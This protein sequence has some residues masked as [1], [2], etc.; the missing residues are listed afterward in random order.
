MS[1][2]LP[3]R[4]KS[5]WHAIA[6]LSRIIKLVH[7]IEPQEKDGLGYTARHVGAKFRRWLPYSLITATVKGTLY[8]WSLYNGYIFAA[9]V[10]LMFSNRKCWKVSLFFS[11]N[12]SGSNN[13]RVRTSTYMVAI[14]PQ[15]PEMFTSIFLNPVI[16]YMYTSPVRAC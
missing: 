4:S 13:L 6:D 11:H 2:L 10:Y 5:T 12:N 1:V 14:L 7:W 16:P 9:D 3:S 15:T 8:T